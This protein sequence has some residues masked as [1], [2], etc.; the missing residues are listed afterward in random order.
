[1][2]LKT[3][4][5]TLA[6]GAGLCSAADSLS[7]QLFRSLAKDSPDNLVF[8]PAGVENILNALKEYS[9]GE[10]LQE[11]NDLPMGKQPQYN[12]HMERADALF[13]TQNLPL[14][15]GVQEP[16]RIDFS[17]SQQ[18]AKTINNWCA[19]HTHDRITNI[20]QPTD[21]SPLTAFVATNAIYLKENWLYAFDPDNSYP[22]EFKLANGTTVPVEMMSHTAKYPAAHGKDWVA[23]ALPYATATPNGEPCYF[24]A[25]QPESNAQDFAAKLTDA[26]YHGILRQLRKSRGKAK[27]SMPAFTLDGNTLKLN[28][29]LKQ[30][31]LSSIFN[32]A[33]FSRLT[34][35]KR[36]IYLS[37]VLQKCF[38]QVNEEGTEAAAA[39]AAVAKFRSIGP[40]IP[41]IVL[42]KPFIWVIGSLSEADTPL[43]MGILQ[44]P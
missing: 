17:Q 38:I 43:F 27:V 41:H 42:D 15:P 2:T 1:M 23:I 3:I 21:L 39:T 9:A 44:N 40:R 14:T 24:I 26:Q 18:A 5:T 20:I 13:V 12:I 30:A 19:Q 7:L 31:G 32:K 11:L 36:D 16:V 22:D 35:T 25:I 4:A 28:Q 34:T 37:E 10:T 6:L 29:A 33:N 8:S